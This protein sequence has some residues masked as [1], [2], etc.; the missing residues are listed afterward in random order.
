MQKPRQ[1]GTVEEDA[2]KR[3]R[4]HVE[5]VRDQETRVGQGKLERKRQGKKSTT[6]NWKQCQGLPWICPHE[7]YTGSDRKK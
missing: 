7:L 3:V 4:A 1:L 6:R 2:G 5:R